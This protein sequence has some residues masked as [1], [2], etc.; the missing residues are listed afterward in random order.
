MEDMGYKMDMSTPEHPQSNA[1]CE[2]IM[3]NLVKI[4]QAAISQNK[5][6]KEL[7][8]LLPSFLR[9]YRSNPHVITGK[10]PSELLIGRNVKT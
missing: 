7:L 6:P 3:G 5:E 4:T 8:Q 1:M 9:E 2:K 10:S